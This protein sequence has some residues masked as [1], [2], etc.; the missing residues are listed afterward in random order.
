ML[1]S[2]RTKENLIAHHAMVT[3]GIS[4]KEVVKFIIQR[5]PVAKNAV[6]DWLIQVRQKIDR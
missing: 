2:S 3:N 4:Q 1:I 5:Y 6:K